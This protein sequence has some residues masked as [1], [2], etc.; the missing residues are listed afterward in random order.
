[1]CKEASEQIYINMKVYPI[2][3]IVSIC[4]H[5]FLLAVLQIS[6][7]LLYINV[8]YILLRKSGKVASEI[9]L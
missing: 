5:Y 9:L 4:L 1:M 6:Y 8:E 2:C 7:R 3:T